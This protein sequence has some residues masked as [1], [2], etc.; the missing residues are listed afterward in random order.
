MNQQAVNYNMLYRKCFSQS[1]EKLT[2]NAASV[3]LRIIVQAMN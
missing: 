3:S 2:E 1:M